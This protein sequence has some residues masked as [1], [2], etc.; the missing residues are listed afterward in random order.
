MRCASLQDD[1]FTPA[2]TARET[3]TFYADVTLPSPHHAARSARVEEVLAAVG[4]AAAG[5]T[6]VRAAAAGWQRLLTISSRTSND[7]VAL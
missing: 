4:L 7:H 2:M 1:N 6:L 5:H 3:L